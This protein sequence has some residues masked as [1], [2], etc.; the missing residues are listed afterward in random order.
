MT[1]E[2]VEKPFIHVTN[3]VLN[4]YFVPGTGV[5]VV[6]KTEKVPVFLEY[7]YNPV[8]EIVSKNVNK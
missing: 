4:V 7:T 2:P 8:E 3:V 1:V 6:N 5:T